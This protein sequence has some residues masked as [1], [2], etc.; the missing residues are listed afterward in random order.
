MGF[1][2]TWKLGT[3]VVKRRDR[4][5]LEVKLVKGCPLIPKDVGLQLLREY[6]EGLEHGVYA[7][8]KPVGSSL[9]ELPSYQRGPN[10]C[11]GKVLGAR[12]WLATRV[13]E[14]RLSRNHQIEWLSAVFPQAPKTFISRAAGLDSDPSALSSEGVP[15]NRR[16]RRSILK[17]RSGEVMIHLFSGEQRWRGPGFIVEVEKSRGS[18]VLNERVYQHM[19]CWA[20]K[21]VVGAVVGGPFCRTA[22]Q[23]RVEGD[24][25]PPPVRDRGSGRWGLKGLPGHLY[26]LVSEDSVLWMRFVLL[27]A[28][29]QAHADKVATGPE[30]PPEPNALELSDQGVPPVGVRDAVDL[31]RWALQQAARNRQR[32]LVLPEVVPRVRA[33]ESRRVLLVWEHPADPATYRPASMEPKGGWASWWAFPEWQDIAKAY[34]VYE[35]RVDQG[36]LGHVRPKPSVVATTSWFLFEELHQR[37][38][39][40]SERAAFDKLPM[41]LGD[42][43]RASQTWACWAQGL[44]RLVQRA[45]AR[46]GADQGLWSQ[47]A[48]RQVFLSK[49][50]EQELQALHEQNDHVPYKKG[51]PVCIA[52]QGRQRSHWRSG[53]P[54]QFAASFDIAGPFVPGKS[55][56]PVASGRDKGLGYRYF[57][58]CAYSVPLSP[59]FVPSGLATGVGGEDIEPLSSAVEE[60]DEDVRLEVVSDLPD[61]SDLFGPAERAVRF[62]ARHKRPEDADMPSGGPGAASEESAISEDAPPLPPPKDPPPV[63]Y[64]T[65]FLGVPLRSKKG[66]EVL[67]AIQSLINKLEAFGFP[68]KRYHA[69]RAQE[70]KSRALV[71]WLRDRGIHGSW[72]PGEAPAGNRA[73]LAV[74]QLKALSRKVLFSA[75]LDAV[76]WPLAVLHASN[77]SWM[78]V[79]LAMGIPQPY[80]LPF[81]V[82]LHARQRTKTGYQSHWR[83]RTVEGQYLGQA[84]HTPGGHLVLVDDTYGKKIL[85]TNTVYPLGPR[86]GAVP[87]PRYRPR[88]KTSPEFLLRAI[89]AVPVL[90]ILNTASGSRFPPGGEWVDLVSLEVGDENDDWDIGSEDSACAQEMLPAVGIEH[91]EA[92]LKP[93][94]GFTTGCRSGA[95]DAS[96]IS[97][98][99]SSA[100]HSANDL[101]QVLESCLGRQQEGPGSF[102]ISELLGVFGWTG[103]A[104]QGGIS[105]LT[106]KVP[107]LVRQLNEFVASRASDFTWSSLQVLRNPSEKKWRSWDQMSSADNWVVTF[108]RFQGGGLWVEGGEGEGGIV[109]R[110]LSGAFRMGRVLEVQGNPARFRGD[111][112]FCLEPWQGDLWMLR[113]WT[114]EG[115][116]LRDPSL[117]SELESVGFRLQACEPPKRN[118]EI[119]EYGVFRTP[120]N[121]GDQVDQATGAETVK[122]LP[123]NEGQTCVEEW[124]VHFPHQL[125]DDEWL[126]RGLS[127]H[128]SI[129]GLR[130]RLSQELSGAPLNGGDLMGI[131]TDLRLVTRAC[132]WWEGLLAVYQPADEVPISIRSLASEVPLRSDEPPV[133][134]QFLQTRTVS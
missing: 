102:E 39:S 62:R 48:A 96:V 78:G 84:P 57:L 117:R 120:R 25:G 69:D 81:G 73:E 72:T 65:M 15:W 125:V 35:A 91:A 107:E 5:P 104:G 4:R 82:K 59:T 100:L 128:E 88:T 113:A 64:R 14:G 50:T 119:F 23:C 67:G 31:A 56:D 110:G 101:I 74:Q 45:W 28:V 8:L 68:I 131:A 47:V 134:D 99:E 121:D 38:L 103:G 85:L 89:Q 70:L 24:G 126:G 21:G 71:A 76:F 90:V 122:D 111:R 112:R 42:R 43:I 116:P 108:G 11:P 132:E 9:S 33:D 129:S 29:A 3:C 16:R 26:D 34:E 114:P 115:Q 58:A 80:L 49:M 52:A 7:A 6:E 63:K 20:I 98:S 44:S 133:V 22:S 37:V 86:A 87:K 118:Q 124:Q 106:S 18:D 36:A 19:L 41:E 83:S 13:K 66:K 77:R 97:T 92:G 61:M 75:G 27:Y 17:A 46:W 40:A 54:G 12:A 1:S 60:A 93:I 94:A 123:T 79:C 53:H 130:K 2:I 32:A 10:P 127:V 95:V 55:F 51:C 105:G 109:G 30:L